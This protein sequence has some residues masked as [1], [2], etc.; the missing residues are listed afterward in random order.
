MFVEWFT[1]FQT[2]SQANPVVSGVLSL[3]GLTVIT[4]LLRNVPRTIFNALK[5]QYTTKY[6]ILN[7]PQGE[8]FY[9]YFNRWFSQNFSERLSRSFAVSGRF[10]HIMNFDDDDH[11]TKKKK[12]RDFTGPGNGIHFFFFHG[13]LFWMDLSDLESSGS[14]RQKK[15]MTIT[16]YGR[17][18]KP[19]ER[20]IDATMPEPRGANNIKFYTWDRDSWVSYGFGGDGIA[21]RPLNS[22]A[23]P[24]EERDFYTARIDHFLENPKWFYDAGLPYKLTFVLHGEP[25]TGKTSL[26]RVLASHYDRSIC[27]LNMARVGDDGFQAAIDELPRKSILLLED[28]DSA[29]AT[30][31]RK[32]VKKKKS[33]KSV[34]ENK[35]EEDEAHEENAVFSLLSLSGILNALDGIRPLDD[36]II[37][38]TTNVPDNIDPAILRSGRVDYMREVKR[39]PDYAVVE[40]AENLFQKSFSVDQFPDEVLGCDINEALLECKGDPDIF[41]EVLNRSE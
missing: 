4:F 24:Q 7:D 8:E 25:G 18:V 3:W 32:G 12:A 22:L 30:G 23:L 2:F 6:T 19:I 39:T 41:V 15:Q 13:R 9:F 40:F 38:M 31:K 27:Y 17:S 34:D 28:F 29:G 35:T 20:L 26:I 36:V 1:W 16:T 37:F 10:F 14:E 33:N 21:K 5:R 11:R